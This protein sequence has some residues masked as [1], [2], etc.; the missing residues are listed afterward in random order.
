MVSGVDDADVSVVDED[1]DAFVFVGATDADVVESGVEA[2]GDFAGVVDAVFADSP[3]PVSAGGGG[4]ASCS[5]GFRWC[6]LA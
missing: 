4:F 1:S 5:I 6:S 2:K 3:V